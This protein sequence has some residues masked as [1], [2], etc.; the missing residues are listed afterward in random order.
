MKTPL[1]IFAFFASIGVS[2]IAYGTCYPNKGGFDGSPDVVRVLKHNWSALHSI[3]ITKELK[4][5]HGPGVC[6]SMFRKASR[7]PWAQPIGENIRCVTFDDFGI[8]SYDSTKSN[9][10]KHQSYVLVLHEE[11]SDVWRVYG[12]DQ[13]YEWTKKGLIAE[14]NKSGKQVPISSGSVPTTGATQRGAT[15]NTSA[16]LPPAESQVE[17]VVK[18]GLGDLLKGFGR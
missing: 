6:N 7:V 13:G 4:G 12:I 17:G 1:Y 8:G 11:S 2:T 9:Y 15:D 5:G 16:P 3:G 14:F 18:K 10:C